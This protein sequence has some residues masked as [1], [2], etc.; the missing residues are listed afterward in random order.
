MS[1]VAR[2]T[3]NSWEALTWINLTTAT[4]LATAN[5]A[6]GS[7][8]VVNSVSTEPIRVSIDASLGYELL[9]LAFIVVA[10]FW[11]SRTRDAIRLAGA[12]A[13]TIL[14][15][16]LLRR[17]DPASLLALGAYLAIVFVVTRNMGHDNIAELL[18]AICVA[19]APPVVATIWIRVVL[20]VRK[21]MRGLSPVAP[22][23]K[24]VKPSA[25]ALADLSF[26][27]PKPDDSQTTDTTTAD[28]P[29]VDQRH[30]TD[31]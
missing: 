20:A 6:L 29:Q 2:G 25:H 15:H 5:V 3:R 9:L 8:L 24:R 17:R 12:D 7:I 1:T 11:R 21:D 19:L 31:D 26:L 18:G 30:H 23:P 13:N 28:A 4:L 22:R 10:A 16:P 27:S 14:R